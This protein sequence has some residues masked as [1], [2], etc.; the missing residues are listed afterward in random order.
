MGIL[1][2]NSLRGANW[3]SMLQK[4]VLPH[5]DGNHLVAGCGTYAGMTE[6]LGGRWAKNMVKNQTVSDA[7]MN[8]G[9]DGYKN[10]VSGVIT[11]DIYFRVSGWEFCFSD[12]LKSYTDPD[13]NADSISYREE[14]VLDVP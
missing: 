10:I 6:E 4:N 9:K 8:M 2:C 7:W 1:A 12:R 3:Q 5:G 14:L 11:N 13:P